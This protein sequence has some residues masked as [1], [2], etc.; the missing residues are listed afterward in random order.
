ML[1]VDEIG[2][3]RRARFREGRSIRGIS[4]DWGIS[5]TTVRKVLR[6]GATPFG[7]A[8][9]CGSGDSTAV[10]RLGDFVSKALKTLSKERKPWRVPWFRRQ[11]S[12]E[13][14]RATS[15]PDC[16]VV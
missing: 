12:P 14:E 13:R 2:K 7:V 3:I 5:R 1:G 6:S 9:D 11:P 4:Q 16:A 15:W 10:E 8:L